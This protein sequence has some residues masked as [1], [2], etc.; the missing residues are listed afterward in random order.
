[1]GQR[2]TKPKRNELLIPES[3]C[4]FF[5]FTSLSLR[6]KHEFSKV[7]P[8]YL[9]CYCVLKYKK[10]NAILNRQDICQLRKSIFVYFFYY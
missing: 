9:E 3:R 5:C 2:N 7:E 4:F 10:E 8:I 6:V 1:M